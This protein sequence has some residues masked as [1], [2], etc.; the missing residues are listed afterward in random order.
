MKKGNILFGWEDLIAGQPLK[1]LTAAFD[2]AGATIVSSSSDG[3]AKR[4]AGVSYKT[5]DIAF[6]DSQQIEL[7]VKQTGDVFQVKLNGQVVP[8]KNPDDHKAAIKE[9][10]AKMDAGRAKF[11]KKLT[12]VRAELPKGTKSV[13]PQKTVALAARVSELD[14]Q[15]ADATTK[16]DALKG[17]LGILDS[18]ALDAVGMLQVEVDGEWKYVFSNNEG[19]IKTTDNKSKALGSDAKSYFEKKFADHNF[20]VVTSSGNIMDSADLDG[21]SLTSDESKLL[22]YYKS[23]SKGAGKPLS[24]HWP[25]MA[26]AL[27]MTQDQAEE[28]VYGLNSSL[29]KKGYLSRKSHN[30]GMSSEDLSLTESALDSAKKLKLSTGDDVHNRA[31]NRT[32]N[33]RSQDGDKV[34]VRSVKGLET[35]DVADLDLVNNLDSTTLDS[36]QSKDNSPDL[37]N[38]AYTTAV[39]LPGQGKVT[40]INAH[41][42]SDG[43]KILNRLRP[44]WTKND[45]LRLAMEHE[46]IGESAETDWSKLVKDTFQKQFG[47]PMEMT[48]YKVSGVARSEFPDDVKDKLRELNE[49]SND[50]K[51]LKVAHAYAAKY[52]GKGSATMDSADPILDRV[53]YEQA[54]HAV[55]AEAVKKDGTKVELIL[56]DGR[57]N[58][59]TAK[60]AVPTGLE[61]PANRKDAIR[62]AKESGN[63]KSVKESGAAMDSV[64]VNPV[65]SNEAVFDGAGGAA[66]NDAVDAIFATATVE[67]GYNGQTA[68]VGLAF[69][70]GKLVEVTK[71][72]MYKSRIVAKDQSEALGKIKADKRYSNVN[73]S[74]GGGK[75]FDYAG[76]PRDTDGTF[77]SGKQGSIK[78]KA[79]HVRFAVKRAFSNP[80][81]K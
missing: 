14:T 15:I 29:V 49:Q 23:I 59:L 76:Q 18:A 80:F 10:V 50:H 21:A 81:R 73:A 17:E 43:A 58:E 16:R 46:D 22:D 75:V 33:V 54:K 24:Y 71:T 45:H 48:D 28:Q 62:V 55:F 64:F 52:Y 30:D 27:G 6:A 39:K 69:L 36:A 78:A 79:Q 56:L 7:Q 77:A 72:G 31:I 67:D 42:A 4:T 8:L 68:K 38:P 63:Y 1:K 40:A 25:S 3:K 20:R 51:S 2:A 5:L 32:G 35:W 37:T 74:V 13:A 9:L 19:S 70:D 60:G 65:R 26:K 66:Y 53:S 44:D 61:K 12:M 47:R 41:T 11:Q 34:L 57:L